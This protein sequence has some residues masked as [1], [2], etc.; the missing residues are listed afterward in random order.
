M[1]TMYGTGPDGLVGNDDCGQMSAW[2]I[3]TTLGMYPFNPASAEYVFGLP[4]IKDATIDLPNGKS[5]RIK[6]KGPAAVSDRSELVSV[7]FNG[8]A[9]PR[10]SIDHKTLLKGG[11]LV[12][13]VK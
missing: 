12:Y 1:N 11:T 5:L 4:F 13:Y 7:V 6:V 9:I 3:W 8:K 10:K 2:Y